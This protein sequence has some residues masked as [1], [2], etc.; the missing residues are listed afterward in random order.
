MKMK[1]IKCSNLE[2]YRKVPTAAKEVSKHSDRKIS[3][4]KDTY[5]TKHIDTIVEEEVQ[6]KVQDFSGPLFHVLNPKTRTNFYKCTDLKKYTTVSENNILQKQ[7][8]VSQA[9]VIDQTEN[10]VQ[11]EAETSQ[12]DHLYMDE[13]KLEDNILMDFTEEVEEETREAEAGREQEEKIQECNLSIKASPMILDLLQFVT[14]TKEPEHVTEEDDEEN[15]IN[16]EAPTTID[17]TKIINSMFNDQHQNS[18]SNQLP[19]IVDFISIGK[20]D[21]TK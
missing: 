7:K 12:E 19:S 15:T 5:S 1:R 9:N 4:K 16:I 13:G 14:I 21:E 20:K 6:K 10:I 8:I 17:L 3:I 11:K 2:S 18:S